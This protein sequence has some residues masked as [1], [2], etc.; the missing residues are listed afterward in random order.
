[1][2]VERAS[3]ADNSLTESTL[4]DFL[5][6]FFLGKKCLDGINALYECHMNGVKCKNLLKS[7]FSQSLVK[8]KIKSGRNSFGH[9]GKR[10]ESS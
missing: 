2:A 1:M 8:T 4:V 9:S 3:E 10:G 5:L 7:M 6:E